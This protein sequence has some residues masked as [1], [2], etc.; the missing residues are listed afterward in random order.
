MQLTMFVAAKTLFSHDIEDDSDAVS[1]NVSLLLEYFTRLVSP[2]FSVLLKLPLPSTLRFRRAVR[3]LDAVIYRMIEQ[4][5][6]SR[7]GGRGPAGA[8]DAGE[9]RRDPGP[10][11]GE[12][13]ARRGAHAADRGARD[14]RQPA[15][16]DPF[17]PCE[18][19]GGGRAHARR[20]ARRCSAGARAS[21]RRTSTACRIRGRSSWRACGSI[22]RA[23]SSAAGA[24]GRAS[25]RLH[26]AQGLGRDA[27]PVRHAARRA[28]LTRRPSSFRPERWTD[29]LRGR[30]PRGAFFP[31]SAG[32]R[33][34][35]GEGFAWQEALLILATLVERWRFEL[36]PGQNIRPRPSVTLRPDAPI[37]MT[38]AR[39]A[40]AGRRTRSALA[41]R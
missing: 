11:D 37:R 14:H 26:G 10:D 25:R 18:R 13:A 34:C 23:G 39:R 17:S 16:L 27:Q 30:L 9:G 33:H 6:A 32:D 38:R 3:D 20:G 5:R 2:F 29:D 21:R 41:R 35:I 28:V 12:A 24:G 36:V 4:R 40:E 1:R 31:F 19:P 7:R 22:R 8:P 15:R